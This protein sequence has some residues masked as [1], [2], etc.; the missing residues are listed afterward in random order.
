M[1]MSLDVTPRTRD[2]YQ[3]ELSHNDHYDLANF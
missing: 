1:S 3:F 2:A